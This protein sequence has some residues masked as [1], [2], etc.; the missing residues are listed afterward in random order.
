MRAGLPPSRRDCGTL[1]LENGEDG[2][3]AWVDMR[4]QYVVLEKRVDTRHGERADVYS[5]GI[6]QVLIS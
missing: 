2:A 1:R 6:E 3:L 4:R 5:L